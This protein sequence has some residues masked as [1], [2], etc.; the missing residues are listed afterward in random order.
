MSVNTIGYVS[1]VEYI[2]SGIDELKSTILELNSNLSETQRGN[3]EIINH[4]NQL[5]EDKYKGEWVTL[6]SDSTPIDIISAINNLQGGC[7]HDGED[8]EDNGDNNGG[9]VGDVDPPT[10]EEPNPPTEEPPKEEPSVP[11]HSCCGIPQEVDPTHY[12]INGAEK[13]IA[14]HVAYWLNKYGVVIL[15]KDDYGKSVR[16]DKGTSTFTTYSELINSLANYL[17]SE[18]FTKT[19]DASGVT[20]SESL[21]NFFVY[22]SNTYCKIRYKNFDLDTL[23]S[24]LNQ[25]AYLP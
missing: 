24:Y 10:G 25:L 18:G 20:G 4:L 13:T 3:T 9:N 22:S 14:Y 15:E 21:T 1:N 6:T 8:G 17:T 7:N 12:C 16:L 23:N 2:E 19:K 11:T 5:G